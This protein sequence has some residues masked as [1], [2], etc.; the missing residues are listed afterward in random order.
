MDGLSAAASGIAVVSLAIQLIQAIQSIQ[1]FFKDVLGAP[2]EVRRLKQDLVQLASILQ[3]VQVVTEMQLDQNGAPN[4]RASLLASLTACGEKL[5]LIK[6]VVDSAKEKLRKSGRVSRH[7]ESF[8][9]VFK[10]KDIEKFEANIHQAMQSLT[11]SMAM[12][13]TV[14]K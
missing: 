2:E 14:L 3:D 4:P 13:L 6:T 10:K 7:W 8:K 11:A 1:D 5:L 9:L 12:N